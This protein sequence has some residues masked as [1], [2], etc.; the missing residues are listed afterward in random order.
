MDNASE[1]P[2]LSTDFLLER[3]ERDR[4]VDR[5]VHGKTKN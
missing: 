4:L 2:E 3:Q 1:Q 5:G